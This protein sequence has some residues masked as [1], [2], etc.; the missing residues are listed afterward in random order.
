MCRERVALVEKQH[1]VSVPKLKRRN[2]PRDL[3]NVQRTAVKAVETSSL[4]ELN[5]GVMR[6]VCLRMKCNDV[7]FLLKREVALEV[8]DEVGLRANAGVANLWAEPLVLV[9]SSQEVHNKGLADD[10]EHFN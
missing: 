1:E 2:R 10:V 4:V 9:E 5:R 7:F 3:W 6:L 8:L